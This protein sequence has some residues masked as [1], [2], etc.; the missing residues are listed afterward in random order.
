M[1]TQ[2]HC[3]VH[4][5]VRHAGVH[6]GSKNH[7]WL[8]WIP[9]LLWMCGHKANPNSNNQCRKD[10]QRKPWRIGGAFA[11]VV[12]SD[13]DRTLSGV[14]GTR[15]SGNWGGHVQVATA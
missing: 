1:P 11:R 13:R 2:A 10:G 3:T 4:K 9:F 14:Q 5:H 6:G 15:D 7:S 8:T 12:G